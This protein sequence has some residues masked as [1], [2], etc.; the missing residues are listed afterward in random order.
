MVALLFTAILIIGLLVA[1]YFWV[2]RGNSLQGASLPTPR[3]PRGLFDNNFHS[4]VS[5]LNATA[6]A[7]TDQTGDSLIHRAQNGDK[8]VLSEAFHRGDR[9]CY[10]GL[11]NELVAAAP[12][13]ASLRELVSFVQSRSLPVSA[14]LAEAFIAVW[15]RR[16]DRTS[17]V[18]MMHLV[19]LADDPKLFGD[20]METALSFWQNGTLTNVTA[21]ELRSLFDSQFWILSADTR[22]SGAGFLLKDSLAR[23]RRQ[24]ETATNV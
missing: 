13:D 1:L 14:K 17:T 11:L 21:S 9:D 6:I 8:T 12:D 3:E 10:D 24:L 20:A 16:P 19:A 15:K 7:S 2:P 4:D 23:A 5:Q 18:T 22:R